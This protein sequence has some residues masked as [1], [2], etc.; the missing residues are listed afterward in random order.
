MN[1]TTLR[2]WYDVFK[3]NKELVEIRIMDPVYK[4]TYSGYFT[5]IETILREIARYDNCSLYFT[6]NVINEACYGR[7][8]HDKISQKPKSTT[9]DNDIV[10][11]KWCLIDVDCEKPSD[12]NSSDEEKSETCFSVWM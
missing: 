5:D 12:T 8:Q 4:K 1:E 3:D 11:R 6:L 10:A 2:Q 9:S 7:E